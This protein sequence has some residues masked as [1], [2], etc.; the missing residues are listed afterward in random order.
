MGSFT[1][2][3]TAVSRLAEREAELLGQPPSSGHVLVALVWDGGGVAAIALRE[4]GVSDPEDIRS[5]LRDAHG[6][7][8]GMDLYS[9]IGAA[10]RQAEALGQGF[11]GTEHQLLAIA[12]D[13]SLKT[14]VLD[15]G[16]RDRARARV[17]EIMQSPG[18][19]GS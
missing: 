16:L 4:L 10:G 2:R 8:L 3:A 18:Y 9:L 14:E 12:E 19:N 13:S 7:G 15:E 1:P 11:I 17:R 6:S 5:R